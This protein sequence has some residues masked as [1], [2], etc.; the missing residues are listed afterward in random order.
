MSNCQYLAIA[1]LEERKGGERKKGVSPT[2]S[3][4][5]PISPDKNKHDGRHNQKR[6]K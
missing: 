1:C 6:K 3:E 4:G 2:I 5:W